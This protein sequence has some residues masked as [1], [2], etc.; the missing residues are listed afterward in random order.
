MAKLFI[1]L[2]PIGSENIVREKIYQH[3]QEKHLPKGINVKIMPSSNQID[4][5]SEI[6]GE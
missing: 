2:L 6:E 5:N 1:I 3:I 4:R